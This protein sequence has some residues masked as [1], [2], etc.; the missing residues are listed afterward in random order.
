MDRIRNEY[1]RG[2][3]KVAP[4]FE[5][6]RSN[7]LA[8][9]GHVLQRDENRITKR[10][11]SM[12]VDGHPSEGRHFFFFFEVESI[13]GPYLPLARRKACVGLAQ[14]LATLAIPTKPLRS[15]FVP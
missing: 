1:I 11:M 9:Y 12:N 13:Y 10:V 15:P 5:K 14:C 8:W 2:S 4:V 6:M 7:R 3:L